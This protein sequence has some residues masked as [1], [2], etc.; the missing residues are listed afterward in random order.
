MGPEFILCPALVL[1]SFLAQKISAW[2]ALPITRA[3][4]SSQ[5]HMCVGGL[6]GLSGRRPCWPGDSVYVEMLFL[7]SLQLFLR[8]LRLICIFLVKNSNFALLSHLYF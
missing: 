8:G 1:L 7:L 3:P 4:V 6:I 2:F 5:H